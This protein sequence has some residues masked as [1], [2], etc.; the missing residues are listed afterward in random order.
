[1][2]K[3]TNNEQEPTPRDNLSDPSVCLHWLQSRYFRR[4]CM[5]TVESAPVSGASKFVGQRV[6]RFESI[7]LLTG[8]GRYGDD[9][10][11][12]PGTLHAAVYRSSY[13]H[14][15]IKSIDVSQAEKMPGVRAV[16]TPDDVRAWSRP[17]INGVKMPM[18]MWAL[19]M[20][21]VRYVGE[22]IAVVIAEDRYLAEDALDGIKIEFEALPAVSSID[23]A[24]S[25]DAAILHEAV[26]T[27]VLHERQFTYGDPESR[28]REAEHTLSLNIEY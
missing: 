14:A 12:K 4:Q 26:G 16:L 18:E 17:F 24:M 1:I 8:R 9:L 27:N 10:G 22:P 21:K 19:A 25:D 2:E 15:R 20:D 5:G 23:G 13:A 28:F 6:E 7:P 3:K 11:V